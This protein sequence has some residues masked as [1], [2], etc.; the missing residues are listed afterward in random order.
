M[1]TRSRGDTSRARL[2]S[3]A[4]RLLSGTS[5]CRPRGWIRNHGCVEFEC[6]SV[7]TCERL[8]R[9]RAHLERVGCELVPV[10][11]APAL[12]ESGGR[13]DGGCFGAGLGGYGDDAERSGVEAAALRG[14]ERGAEY[15]GVVGHLDQEAPSTSAPSGSVNWRSKG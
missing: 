8:A 5:R 9:T 1:A 14:I 10:A 15:V 7:D 13:D 6:L 3:A 4:V 12:P 2:A 11:A